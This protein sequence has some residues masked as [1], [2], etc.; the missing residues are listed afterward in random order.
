M[1]PAQILMK[2]F[3]SCTDWAWW[4]IEPKQAVAHQSNAG[5][6]SP[7]RANK[8]N[9]AHTHLI[10]LNSRSRGPENRPD[11]ALFLKD[12]LGED[13][14]DGTLYLPSIRQTAAGS[15]IDEYGVNLR[16]NAELDRFQR[17][18]TFVIPLPSSIKNFV[19]DDR[20]TPGGGGSRFGV[21]ELVTSDIWSGIF[22][23]KG[24][25]ESRC[26]ARTWL[27]RAPKSKTV[28]CLNRISGCLRPIMVAN[29][30]L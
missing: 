27:A 20:G 21:P 17:V 15:P 12:H 29:L 18:S 22:S 24:P 6:W 5:F 8:A 11:C 19:N 7:K 9:K 23:A 25:S 14:G 28:G 10:S 13:S 3:G 2:H 16:C 1:L 4:A 30:F 26:A